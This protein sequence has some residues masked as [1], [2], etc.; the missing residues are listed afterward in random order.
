VTKKLRTVIGIDHGR[1][2]LARLFSARALREFVPCGT[3]VE[4]GEIVSDPGVLLD[5]PEI[6]HA[7]KTDSPGRSIAR[8]PIRWRGAA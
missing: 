3:S 2:T 7:A 4:N 1:N 5:V 8:R 6:S